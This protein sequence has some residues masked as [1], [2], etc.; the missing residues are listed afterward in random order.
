MGTPINVL[1]V[2]DSED[3]AF[4]LLREFR[5]GDYEP[6]HIRVDTAPMLKG[7]LEMSKWDIVLSDYSMPQFSA[8]EALSMLQESGMDIPFIVISGGIDEKT[9]VDLMKAGAQDYLY[10][11]NL[12]RL[13][14]IVIRELKESEIRQERKQAKE[15]LQQS[16]EMLQLVIDN[17]PEHVFWKNRNSVYL[18]CNK[19]FLEAT[20]LE[21]PEDIIGKTDYD[22]PW[23]QKESDF[24]RE[25]DRRIIE[26]GIPEF[27]IIESLHNTEG[28]YV[29]LD[30]NKVPLRDSDGDIIGILGT[31][32]DITERKL[33]AEKNTQL[34][35]QLHQ[36]QKMEAIGRLAG[37]IAHDFNNLLTV[38]I[39]YSKMAMRS[40][41]EES[42]AWKKIDEINNAGERAAALTRQLLAFS[43][44][45]IIKPQ[46]IN[47]NAIVADMKKMIGRL[48]GENVKLT[49]NLHSDLGNIKADQG[50]IEQ[51]I[52]NLTINARDAMPEGGNVTV[53]TSTVTM[54]EETDISQF[55]LPPGNYA[56]LS[57]IDTGCGMDEDT[58]SQIFEP[59]FTTKDVNKGTGL[60][61]STVYGIVQQNK[62][63]IAVESTVGEGTVFQIYFPLT[64]ESPPVKDSKPLLPEML[65]GKEKILLVEDEEKVRELMCELLRSNGYDV[66]TANNGQEGLNIFEHNQDSIDLVITDVIMPKM[67]GKEMAD[68]MRQQR[69]NLN[70]VYISGYTEDTIS[71]HGMLDSNAELIKKPFDPDQFVKKIREILD[72]RLNTV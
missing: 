7:T 72:E 20:G 71:R 62:G 65:K 47:L 64:A 28:Q 48:I 2:D 1:I 13:I 8:H 9:A 66:I 37:G 4:L 42:D 56:K 35:Q 67:D 69:P 43:R 24:Y 23:K 10:K 49:T 16:Q 68:R 59:F 25:C 21:K 17:I 12:A 22:L 38:I 32:E 6:K 55:K 70:M 18:G 29:W 50:Q 44:K 45:Q 27:H 14:P 11:D 53:L 30:T 19:N 60:G 63:A 40:I 52:L 51:I 46:I 33:A 15:A 39:G 31:F 5:R 41:D 36:S 3:D 54:N 57:V 26:T 34:E 61:L 58:Q